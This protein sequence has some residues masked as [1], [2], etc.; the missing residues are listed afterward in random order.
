MNGDPGTSADFLLSLL[1][2]K[3]ER[4]VVLLIGRDLEPEEVLRELL[5]G[6]GD[7]NARV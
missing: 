7:P 4:R 5:K 2:D 6:E 3:A 1:E